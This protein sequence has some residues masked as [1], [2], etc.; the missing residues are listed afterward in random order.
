MR[1]LRDNHTQEDSNEKALRSFLKEYIDKDYD[2][3]NR[4]DRIDI[5]KKNYNF[6]DKHSCSHYYSK[7]I[8]DEWCRFCKVHPTRNKSELTELALIYG[9][10]VI[11]N[12]NV[13]IQIDIPKETM[14]KQTLDD[15]L[16]EIVCFPDLEKWLSDTE[17]TIKSGQPIHPNKIKKLHEIIREVNKIKT[18]S[19]KMNI[20]LEEAINRIE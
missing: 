19:E 18:K 10:M 13:L 6:D 20:L 14:E 3:L 5:F 15:K 7:T 11:P 8:Y 4:I 9:M 1:D 12:E 17:Q 16:R 2:S